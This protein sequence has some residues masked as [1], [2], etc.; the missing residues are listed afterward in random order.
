MALHPVEHVLYFSSI[1]IHF[2]V[3]THPIHVLFHMLAMTIGAMIG[4]TG[5]T[6]FLSK[7]KIE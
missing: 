2:V 1:L 5:L 6:D 3:P 7:I 4:H